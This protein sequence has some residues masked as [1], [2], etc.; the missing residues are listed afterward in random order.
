MSM[1]S[2]RIVKSFAL[3]TVLIASGCGY[4]DYPGHPGHSTDKEAYVPAWS[5][6]ISG[7]GDEYDGTYVYSVKYDT[8]GWQRDNYNFK[9]QITSYR[10]KV[11][12]SY[13]HRPN[14]F[15]DADGF[16][17]ATGFSGGQFGKYWQA[18][19][20]DA[21]NY[22]GLD[23]FDR[24]HPLDAD[25]NWIEPV[26]VLVTDTPEQE[27]DKVDWDLQSVTQN[28][29]SILKTMIANG[30]KVDNLSLNVTGLEFNGSVQKVDAFKLEFSTNGSGQNHIAI[31]N[32]PAAKSVIKKILENTQSLKTV[33]LKLH[34]DNGMAVA[35]P[36]GMSIKFNHNALAKLAK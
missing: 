21:N 32:Q 3:A 36:K 2:N 29:S 5:T 35:L 17:Y 16:K 20:T 33:D 22:G 7:F 31:R 1:T 23:N 9:V 8:R 34:F 27:V 13:P 28:A 24:S 19:D 14:I 26:L 10:N 18:L 6:V 25:G 15:P 4:S 12:D 30:G 11:T